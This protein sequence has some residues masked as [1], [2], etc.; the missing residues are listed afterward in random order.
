MYAKLHAI[1]PCYN[2]LFNINWV[3]FFDRKRLFS[4]INELLTVFEV[5]T[6]RKPIKDKPMVS[7]D[8]GRKSRGSTKVRKMK[9]K[10]FLISWFSHLS[11]NLSLKENRFPKFSQ[12]PN[13]ISEPTHTIEISKLLKQFKRIRRKHNVSSTPEPK[14]QENQSDTTNLYRTPLPPTIYWYHSLK[15]NFRSSGFGQFLGF[16]LLDTM[17]VGFYSSKN[18]CKIFNLR[19]WRICIGKPDIGTKIMAYN[20]CKKKLKKE[21]LQR[22]NTLT[23]R[24]INSLFWITHQYKNVTVE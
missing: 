1:F 8:S 3:D 4:L 17:V 5:V 21:T 11:L 13:R 22:L 10:L 12:P 14:P 15:N 6:E 9:L 2:C 19:Y 24:K 23:G 7:V 16:G 18:S 20:L